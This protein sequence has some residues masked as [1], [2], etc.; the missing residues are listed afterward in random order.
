[1]AKPTKTALLRQVESF[2]S[3]LPLRGVARLYGENNLLSIAFLNLEKSQRGQYY[4]FFGDKACEVESLDEQSFYLDK[5]A[6]NNS[7]VLVGLLDGD[8]VSPVLVGSFS[9]QN[10]NLNE[11]IENAKKHFKKQ[12]AEKEERAVFQEEIYNDEA[13]ASTNY[14]ELERKEKGCKGAIDERAVD[15][16]ESTCSQNSTREEEKEKLF[17]SEEALFSGDSQ[18]E[19]EELVN[20]YSK[21]KGEIEALFKEHPKEE[22]LCKM[23]EDSKWV[24][25]GDGEKYYAVG[26]IFCNNQ[27]EYICY[28][29]P[30]RYDQDRKEKGFSSFI[31][32]SPFDLKGDGYWVSFQC[33]K[34]GK[35]VE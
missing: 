29:L 13:I 11:A 33:A 30:G 34:S 2:K 7:V 24:K 6:V 10:I 28:G 20:F 27:P 12:G 9:S 15:N 3:S 32:I 1:M 16:E 14:F 21:I 35:C 25:I 22:R 18:I 17:D 19:Q 23:V 31:P 26:I 8:N 4:L 5:D